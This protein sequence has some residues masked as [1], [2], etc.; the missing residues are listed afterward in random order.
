[1]MG[2]ITPG[3]NGKPGRMET[4]LTQ[5]RGAFARSE[6]GWA[7]PVLQPRGGPSND[8][9]SGSGT[10][11][12]VLV[13]L[14]VVLA[15][16]A[17]IAAVS[18]V[19][20]FL[21]A[22]VLLHIDGVAAAD[23]HFVS[24]LAAH[25]TPSERTFDDRLDHRR[26]ESCSRSSSARPLWPCG[27]AHW[28]IAAFV[29]FVLAVESASYRITTLVVH[30]H[31][32]ASSAREP[33]RERELSVRP[34]GGLDRRLLRARAPAHLAIRQ[35]RL[36]HRA[37]G[38][39]LLDPGL[40][41]RF[42][43]CI[44]GCTIR[45]TSRAESS[46]GSP[47]SRCS[48]SPA[49]QRARPPRAGR[50]RVH[51]GRASSPTPA[52]R[53]AAACSSC[54][55]C[56]SAEGVADPL[57]LEV[58]KSRKAPQQVERALD[59]GAELVFAWGGDG[60]VQRCV[61]VARRLGR[62]RSR[63]SPPGPRTCFAT[64]LGIP[65]DIEQAVEIGLHGDAPQ[66]DVGRFNGERFAVMA[67]AGF[68]AAMIR[69]ADGGLKDRLGRAAYVWSGLEEPARRSRSSA[70]IKVDGVS[71]YEGEATL[72]SG[73]QRRR[74]VRRRRGLRGRAARRRLARGRRRHRRG[75]RP[76][77]ADGCTD[78]RRDAERVAVRAGDQGDA[79]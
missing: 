25:R 5:P 79:R 51:E 43:A 33:A 10:G 48:S 78:R 36:P 11:H 4:T 74:P 66:L 7:A 68:D 15:G 32:P 17:L 72:H 12:P 30:R 37:S 50:A 35:P 55:G 52:R 3:A 16:L 27:P 77:G 23:E 56:S 22:R 21:V 44:A 65:K 38:L 69:D 9:P 40:R 71:W 53:S 60:M 19:L 20:G 54:G 24:W 47:R 58:P 64:N 13:F 41:R 31:R 28:R 63:S 67:G 8:S 49:V 57:W 76:V 70:E 2:G 73:R 45:S 6:E 46:S 39:A 34:H 59:D 42:A 75:L 14:A 26:A 29:V 1:M 62:R 18:T 61:D